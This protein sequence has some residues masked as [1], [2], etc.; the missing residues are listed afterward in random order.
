MQLGPINNF[1]A[2]YAEALYMK[3]GQHAFLIKY[4]SHF[5]IYFKLHIRQ[6]RICLRNKIGSAQCQEYILELI[7]RHIIAAF[8]VARILK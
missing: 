5:L 4:V 1:S 3:K 8:T 6:W 7:K 2:I